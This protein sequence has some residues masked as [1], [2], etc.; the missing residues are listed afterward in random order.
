MSEQIKETTNN[1]K[2]FFG[3]AVGVVEE[4]AH[5]ASFGVEELKTKASHTVEDGFAEAKRLVKKGEQ[6]AEHLMDDTAHLIK[7]D[8]FRSVGIT[9]GVGFGVGLGLGIFAGWLLPHRTKNSSR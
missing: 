6:A 8:P 1:E 2:G 4:A 9:F 5:Q 3:A 7:H